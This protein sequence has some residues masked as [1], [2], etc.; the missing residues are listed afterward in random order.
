MIHTAVVIA[1]IDGKNETWRNRMKREIFQ[2]CYTNA[3][4]L[5]GGVTRT[6]WKAVATSENIP[7]KAFDDCVRVHVINSRIFQEM[8]DEHGNILT[9]YELVGTDEYLLFYRTKYGLRDIAGRYNMF[10]HAYVF[11]WKEVMQQ[12]NLFLGLKESNFKENIEEA[13]KKVLAQLEYMP[14]FN[15]QDALTR[16]HLTRNTYVTLIQCIYAEMYLH[17]EVTRPFYIQY[18]GSYGMMCVILYCI[19]CGIPH[20]MRKQFSVASGEGNDTANR[21]VIFSEFAERHES[22]FIPETGENNVLFGNDLE[23]IEDGGYIDYAVKHYSSVL[24]MEKYFGYL[25]EKANM[26]GDNSCS[27]ERILKIVHQNR[28]G[29][30]VAKWS[31]SELRRNFSKALSANSRYNSNEMEKY[32]AKI[33][34]EILERKLALTTEAEKR[35]DKQLERA[36][37]EELISVGKQYRRV[38]FNALPTIEDKVNKLKN[39]SPKAFQEY[40]AFLSEFDEGIS[41]LN[42]YYLEVLFGEEVSWGQLQDGWDNI[43]DL[44]NLTDVTDK[45]QQCAYQLYQNELNMAEDKVESYK[46]YM[47][48][49]KQL[50]K[51]DSVQVK[52]CEKIAKEDYWQ[53]LRFS[54]FSFDDSAKNDYQYMQVKESD[55][56]FCKMFMDYINILEKSKYYGEIGYFKAV[57]EFFNEYSD[58]IQKIEINQGVGERRAAIDKLINA[59]L[60][61]L[62]SE[63]Q[64]FDEFKRWT[65]IASMIS[66]QEV[67][68]I[69]LEIRHKL[70]ICES[71]YATLQ[72]DYISFMK[73]DK[74]KYNDKI[75]KKMN[76]LMINYCKKH[77][78]ENQIPLDMWLSIAIYEYKDKN[79]FGIFDQYD[80]EILNEDAAVVVKS[81]KLF[82]NNPDEE[83]CRNYI[84]EAEAYVKDR[85]EQGKIVKLWITEANILLK[86]NEKN[87]KNKT[88]GNNKKINS[89]KNEKNDI[90]QEKRNFVYGK[91]EDSDEEDDYSYNQERKKR[92]IKEQ[93]KETKKEMFAPVEQSCAE[94]EVT[95]M[96][97]NDGDHGTLK[98]ESRDRTCDDLKKK[99][100]HSRKKE[101]KAEKGIFSFLRNMFFGSR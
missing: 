5:V 73:I 13:S 85:G 21:N 99:S 34:P 77:D 38:Q 3:A 51:Y 56:A 70:S 67:L 43:Q 95:T 63:A 92:K 53:V 96:Q 93:Q 14:V 89:K 50:L 84:A 74:G 42:K 47:S 91:K 2:C 16:G 62:P 52:E 45:L 29:I 26:F 78:K 37:T 97:D 57:L 33:I 44:P 9:L 101:Q 54:T 10:S 25:D 12:P 23:D 59:A 98:E 39:F 18:D 1:V 58:E 19:Y 90:N 28:N 71:D 82:L 48:F 68:S 75:H 8:K 41:I 7:N 79:I 49:M 55:S 15:L 65:K 64:R 36:M 83:L 87:K 4:E 17:G 69:M 60:Y 27:D 76:Q 100:I 24:E 31:N 20:Y 61:E 46:K 32:I 86:L 80:A 11:P 40:R 81:S 30:N 66:S 94:V 35:L 88:K 6:G 72:D 22:Y